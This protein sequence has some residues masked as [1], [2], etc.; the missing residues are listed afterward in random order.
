VGRA[1]GVGRAHGA[2]G[3]EGDEDKKTTGKL[4]KEEMTKKRKKSEGGG[5]EKGMH[6]LSPYLRLASDVAEQTEEN[7][8][9]LIKEEMT[10]KGKNLKEVQKKECIFYRLTFVWQAMQV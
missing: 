9:K 1:S 10:K 3:D 2:P 6:I 7:N 8:R 5:A 4:I